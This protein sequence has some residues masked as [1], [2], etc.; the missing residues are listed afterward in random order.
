MRRICCFLMM[1]AMILTLSACSF[2]TLDPDPDVTTLTPKPP[3]SE[4]SENPSSDTEKPVTDTEKKP[5]YFTKKIADLTEKEQDELAEYLFETYIPCSY[6]IFADGSKISSP[7]VWSSVEALNRK[8]DGDT[9]AAS[10][11]LENVQKKVKIYFPDTDFNPEK[12]RVY[13]KETKTF[14]PSP[15]DN[16][17]YVLLSY[18]VKGGN[19]TV[20]YEDKPDANDPEFVPEK[21]ATTLKNSTA[22]GYFSFVSSVKTDAVG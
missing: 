16:F 7:S 10:R 4:H 19:I 17:E 2:L 8:L 22:E 11:T 3:F 6:G 5:A 1:G 9:S 20:Y 18:E 13:D 12:V 14:A 15:A 21:Y